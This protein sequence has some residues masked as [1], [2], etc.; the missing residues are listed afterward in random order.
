MST[1]ALGARHTGVGLSFPQDTGHLDAPTWLKAR[2]AGGM[3]GWACPGEAQCLDSDPSNQGSPD[4]E[5]ETPVMSQTRTTLGEALYNIGRGPL[6][7]HGSEGSR[8]QFYTPKRHLGHGEQRK[9]SQGGGVNPRPWTGQGVMPISRNS[10]GGVGLG[11]LG[12]PGRWVTVASLWG[13]VGF[14]G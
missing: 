11:S 8:Q 3:L 2:G 10:L 4:R 7:F 1:L 14:I 5:V 9:Q 6:A 12:N 13:P